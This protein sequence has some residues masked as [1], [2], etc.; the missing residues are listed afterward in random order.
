MGGLQDLVPQLVPAHP[1]LFLPLWHRVPI[2]L[3]GL[4]NPHLCPKR[5]GRCAPSL[6]MP[7]GWRVVGT[8]GAREARQTGSLLLPELVKHCP[9]PVR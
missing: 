1:C 9:R 8:P 4:Q 6:V 3:R 7:A 5:L 2:Q